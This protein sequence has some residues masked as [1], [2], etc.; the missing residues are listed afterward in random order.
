MEISNLSS[1]FMEVPCMA[2][3]AFPIRRPPSCAFRRV[4]VIA[5]ATISGIP[6]SFIAAHGSTHNSHII[7]DHAHVYARILLAKAR[8]AWPKPV[9]QGSSRGRLGIASLQRGGRP[10]CASAQTWH[11]APIR[12]QGRPKRISG[13]SVANRHAVQFRSVHI[14]VF[15]DRSV[16]LFFAGKAP[17]ADARRD[18]VGYRLARILQLRRPLSPPAA[19]SL[20]DRLQFL[21]RSDAAEK[22][23]SCPLGNR[24]RRRSIA[25]LLFQICRVF[26]RDPQRRDRH[27][28]AK[29][30]YCSADRHLV[31]HVHANRLSGR[32]LPWRGARVRTISLH[33]FRLVFPSSH[34]RSD[35]SSQ[36]NHAA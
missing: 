5:V 16:G 6:L 18:V 31:F 3:E 14:R 11:A 22:P 19:D 29:S 4:W 9:E 34:C 23:K 33:A 25:A 17:G 36:R 1:W 10:L 27:R 12:P 30:E 28:S 7:P 2:G 20:V 35:L 13:G 21:H 15:A 24:R 8:S 26:G 32:R